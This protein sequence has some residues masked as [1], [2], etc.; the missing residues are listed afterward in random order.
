MS[1][2]ITYGATNGSSVKVYLGR[3]L[4]GTIKPNGVLWCYY[5]KGCNTPGASLPSIAAV[6]RSLESA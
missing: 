1:K 3:R 4:A 6:K 2:T 5:P